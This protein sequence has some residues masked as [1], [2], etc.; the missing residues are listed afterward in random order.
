MGSASKTATIAIART[1]FQALAPH[2]VEHGVTSSEVEALLRVVIVQEAAKVFV[3]IGQR[4]NASRVSIKTGV[5]RHVVAELLK[6][7]PTLDR[8][9]SARRDATSRVITGWLTDPKYS[10][11]S[12][13]RALAIGDPQSKGLTAWSLAQRY[14]PGVWPRLVIDELIRL[15]YVH[16]LPDGKLQ[17][18]ATSVQQ[19]AAQHSGDESS[20]RMLC[21]A[22]QSCVQ[23]L[24]PRRRNRTWRATQRVE[25]G[26]A[27]V[28]LVRK[29]IR[30]RLDRTFAELA[31]ELASTRWKAPSK[32]RGGRV[33]I[34]V[35]AFAFEKAVTKVSMS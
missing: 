19:S 15:D 30:D 12:A 34:G 8:T 28:P 22:V 18:N 3:Q 31:E 21:D 16:V 20:L 4:A 26:H 6:N 1:L 11:N 24:Q 27:T 25:L 23:E 17:C 29:M 33:L 7:P 2:L 10:K 14:A 5:D 35:S 9:A 32:E 13:P